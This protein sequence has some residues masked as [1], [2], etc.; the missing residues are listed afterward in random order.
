M[1][2]DQPARRVPPLVP[3]DAPEFVRDVTAVMMAGRGDEIPV[4]AMPVDGTFPP[5]TTALREAQYRRR[6]AASGTPISASSAASA[7]SSARTAS[8]APN[9]T[10]E[11][12]LAEAPAGFKSAPVNARGFPIAASRC[13][14]YVEDCTGC[15]ICVEDCP[16]LS[17][18]RARDTA[19]S[20]WPTSCR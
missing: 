7:A 16:A 20:T 13:R 8:S 3:A 4:S 1:P 18:T 11:E 12:A 15:G 2:R 5:G 10:T 17:P 14:F 6:G 9:T 19:P